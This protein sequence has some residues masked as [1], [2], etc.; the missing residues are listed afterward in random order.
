MTA[1]QATVL[2]IV[3]A[4]VLA[5]LCSY[6]GGRIHQWRRQD[7]ERSLA[8]RD[9]FTRA[10]SAMANSPSPA[11]WPHLLRGAAHKS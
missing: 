10:A 7:Q 1:V 4:V 9:G 8:F 5:S 2:Q 11:E 3:S 6:L